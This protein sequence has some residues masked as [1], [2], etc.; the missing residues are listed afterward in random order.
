MDETTSF[1]NDLE[2]DENYRDPD[3]IRTERLVNEE[4]EFHFTTP[5]E[6][7]YDQQL[8]EHILRESLL[9]ENIN[10]MDTREKENR[11]EMCKE[12][13]QTLKRTKRYIPEDDLMYKIIID[14]CDESGSLALENEIFEKFHQTLML[15]VE[16]KKVSQETANYIVM[17]TDVQLH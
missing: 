14:F 16:K 8:L 13:L 10:P 11:S 6:P 7:D 15:L 2:F 4:D 5:D 3:P 17:N 9:P 1:V 12:L